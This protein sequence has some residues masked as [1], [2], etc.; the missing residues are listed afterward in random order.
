[1]NFAFRECLEALPAPTGD[2]RGDL[3]AVARVTRK[4]HARW[5]GLASMTRCRAV[6]RRTTP[7]AEWG[8][9]SCLEGA[10]R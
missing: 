5:P 3:E 2:W 8:P 10:I 1:M 9:F 4:T 6:R 7:E